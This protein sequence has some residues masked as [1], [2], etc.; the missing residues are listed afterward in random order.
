MTTM[1][2]EIINQT[3]RIWLNDSFGGW[4]PGNG[5][6]EFPMVFYTVGVRE[7]RAKEMRVDLERELVRNFP[8]GFFKT[9]RSYK[10]VAEA[11]QRSNPELSNP[12]EVACRILATAHVVGFLKLD[13]P[14][15]APDA[16]AEEAWAIARNGGLAAVPA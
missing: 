15:R 4:T 13:V 8:E 2:L 12:E 9:R 16:S 10:E 7:G 14:V 5:I 6:T 11:L 3:A 1:L